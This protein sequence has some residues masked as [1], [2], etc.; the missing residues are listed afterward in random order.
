MRPW[1][2]ICALLALGCSVAPVG[3]L[4]PP[5][6]AATGQDGPPLCLPGAQV[7]C[8]CVGGSTGAQVCALDGRSLGPCGCP[9][10]DAG[11]DAAIADA[12]APRDAPT[13][14]T[15]CAPGDVEPCFCPGAIGERT[16]AADGWGACR[17]PA[18]DAGAAPDVREPLDVVAVSDVADASCAADLLSDPTNCGACGRICTAP[19]GF[20]V[21]CRSGACGV[22]GPIMCPAAWANCNGSEVDGCE[23]SLST[24]ANCGACGR[25]CGS[26]GVRANC[27]GGACQEDAV[28]L[29]GWRRCGGLS[30]PCE[31]I[32]TPDQCGE[33]GTRCVAANATPECISPRLG[34]WRCSFTCNPGFGDC[35]RREAT[36]CETDLRTTAAHCGTC[37]VPC[38]SGFRCVDSACVR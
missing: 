9:G 1:L 29:P 2:T 20:G 18:A 37:G 3:V 21:E 30:A 6:D 34:D 27:N 10:A 5:G 32:Q 28:C 8:A 38:P 4:Q 14:D 24:L 36:G 13:T 22:V 23:T 11:T 35:D 19:R 15:G 26:P 7:A 16:C 12:P 33:C 17:C 31:S 25:T